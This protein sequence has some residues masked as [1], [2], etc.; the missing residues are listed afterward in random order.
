LFISAIHDEFR[1]FSKD[2]FAIR[3]QPS[4]PHIWKTPKTSIDHAL[5]WKMS[6]LTVIIQS[7]RFSLRKEKKE[8]NKIGK[9]RFD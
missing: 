8:K 1:T 7:M 5:L 4:N 3:K 2:H 6:L 9:I